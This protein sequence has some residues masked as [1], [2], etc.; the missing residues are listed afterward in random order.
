[1]LRLPRW[2]LCASAA[3]S[4]FAGCGNDV[5]PVT[6]DAPCAGT[7]LGARCLTTLASGEAGPWGVAIHG[8]DVVWTTLGASDA[9]GKLIGALRTVPLAG[10]APTTLV[11]PTTGARAIAVDDAAL[12]WTE[13]DGVTWSVRRAPFAAG[14]AA[15]TLFSATDDGPGA[16]IL[17]DPSHIDAIGG[18]TVV[19]VPRDGSA[20]S[21]LTVGDQPRSLAADATHLYWVTQGTSSIAPAL[22][23]ASLAGGAA[24]TLA[25]LT[26]PGSEVAVDATRVYW[27]DGLGSDGT[28]QAM[29]LQ[30]GAPVTL[31]TGL[32]FTGAL[33][34]D[35]AYA[36]VAFTGA[37]DEPNTPY[38]PLGGG[39]LRVPLA[40][41]PAEVLVSEQGE[42]H[43]LALAGDGLV[44]ASY[45][46]GTIQR[47]S[48][49]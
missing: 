10:G 5:V 29:P 37:F 28:L 38:D 2:A 24:E 23:R 14:S 7:R 11:A 30:G 34:L 43:G 47:L 31:T 20:P 48:P 39:I 42:I 33:V 22:R 35:D 36:Y 9:A 6:H 46:V 15:A 44:W 27:T 8:S 17:V 4:L 40:G 19:V 25:T 1:M 12:V 18:N 45:S 3:L 49:L 32:P 41:G 16:D 26:R 21:L 13:H